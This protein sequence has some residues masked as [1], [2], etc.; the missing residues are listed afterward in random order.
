MLL[1]GNARRAQWA[2][3]LLDGKIGIEAFALSFWMRVLDDERIRTQ[4]SVAKWAVA[5][6]AKAIPIRTVPGDWIL[7]ALAREDVGAEVGRWLSAAE[8]LP[9][10]IDLERIKGLV[11]DPARRDLAFSLLG[12]AKLVSPDEVGLGWLLALGRRA[13]PRLHEWAHR[14][15]LE[16]MRPQHFAEGKPDPKA[17]V[18]RLFAIAFGPKESEA[19]RAF[20]QTFLRCHHP[21][22][23]PEQSESKQ[24]DVKPS[25]AREEYSKERIWPALF[26]ARPDVRR[27]AVAITRVEL[28]RWG[29]QAEVYELAESSAKEVRRI[30]YD[31]LQQAGEAHADPDLA[32]RPEELDAAQIFSMTESRAR[33]SRDVAIELIR[34][35]YA[36]IGGVERLGWLMQSADREVRFFAVRLLWEKHRPRGLPAEW[37]SKRGLSDAGPFTDAEALRDLLRR[38]LFTIPPGR[39]MGELEGAR[40]KKLP[41]GVA[42]RNL[43]AIVRDLALEDRAFAEIVAPVLA[44]QTGSKA[45]GEWEACL[46]AL[47]TLRSAHSIAF[48]ELV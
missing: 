8:A 3:K 29:A 34:K 45:K 9:A 24:F 46:S 21:K 37:L 31:A 25:I 11:F 32:L 36:R 38:L 20:A 35:H 22:I 30:A 27:F 19:A 14:Y 44:A 47:L 48:E 40:A 28:R 16:H 15:L 43:I 41:A 5:R 17:G 6:L 1:S 13:D 2:Q 12:N 4:L 39:S 42:K 18:V 33:A 23:G 10:G 7:Q 26:D